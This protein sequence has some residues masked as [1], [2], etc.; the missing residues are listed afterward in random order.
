[1]YVLFTIL[2]KCVCCISLTENACG[3]C[4]RIH[5]FVDV[6]WFLVKYNLP[7]ATEYILCVCRSF[8]CIS[9]AF[10]SLFT[11]HLLSVLYTYMCLLFITCT[12][13]VSM[14]LS[15]W[16]NS[17]C[18]SVEN[19]MIIWFFWEVVVMKFSFAGNCMTWLYVDFRVYRFE[20]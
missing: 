16:H 4:W 20:N 15:L 19:I 18:D 5:C 3:I 14:F 17:T 1:M 10:I 11:R 13:F 2:N 8:V 9:F 6:L 12:E 7:A